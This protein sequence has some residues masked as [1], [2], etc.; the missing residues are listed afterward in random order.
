MRNG[1]IFHLKVNAEIGN[2]DG[3]MPLKDT[4]TQKLGH[5]SLKNSKFVKIILNYLQKRG[6]DEISHTTKKSPI[7][8]KFIKIPRF[9]KNPSFIGDPRKMPNSL[10]KI[11]KV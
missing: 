4:G 10:N 2:F 1:K 6:F 3:E 8:P 5:L 11:L 9:P 7:F